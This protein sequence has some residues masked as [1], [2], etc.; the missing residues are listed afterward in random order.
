M[1]TAKATEDVVSGWV[2]LA[3]GIRC[4]LLVVS[5]MGI[6]CRNLVHDFVI[7]QYP[8]SNDFMIVVM[9]TSIFQ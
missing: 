8:S 1:T 4:I 3:R 6:T 5:Y 2:V 7:F 9:A